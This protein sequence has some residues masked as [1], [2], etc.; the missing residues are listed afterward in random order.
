MK[1][2][3]VIV[4]G[5]SG[6]RMGTQV[7]KQFLLLHGKPVLWYTLEVFLR[8]YEDLD[9]ILVAPE[10]HMETARTVVYATMAPE[11]VRIVEGGATRFQSVRNGLQPICE[12][13]VIFVHDGVRCLLSTELVHSCYEQAV[14]LGSAIPVVDSKDSV[15]VVT[16]ADSAAIDRSRVKLV[17]TPQTFLS[18]ILLPAYAQEYRE[19]FTD[20]ASVVEASGGKVHL[21]AGE[22]N[23]IKITTPIDLVIAEKLLI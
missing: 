2:Y 9:I 11:R 5:G 17:Q 12:E 8:A 18:R 23:N 10:E 21:V 7:P 13:A 19:S 3:A 16:G 15:R 1:K 14:R 22:T 6:H 4:A 20:E